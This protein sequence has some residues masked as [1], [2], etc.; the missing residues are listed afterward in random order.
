MQL[1]LC[2]NDAL[3]TVY[4]QNTYIYHYRESISMMN[5]TKAILQKLGDPAAHVNKK[6]TNFVLV[7]EGGHGAWC[8]YKLAD[9]LQ[10]SGHT[11]IVFDLAASGLHPTRPDHIY[12]LQQYAEPLLEALRSISDSE[13]VSQI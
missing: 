13:K 12:S 2:K 11:A 6:P 8:W 4:Q 9:L 5:S 1:I 7:H 3:T 10:K